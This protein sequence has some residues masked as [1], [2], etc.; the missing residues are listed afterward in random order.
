MDLVTLLNPSLSLD[1]G[2]MN[3]K[4]ASPQVIGPIL[5]QDE[6]MIGVVGLNGKTFLPLVAGSIGLTLG[7]I[8]TSG[9]STDIRFDV[10]SRGELSPSIP[11]FTINYLSRD[12]STS[13]ADH[14]IVYFTTT[15]G[16]AAQGSC[17]R[18]STRENCVGLAGVRSSSR[19]GI[20]VA[21][22]PPCTNC[23]GTN[24]ATSSNRYLVP[25]SP[26]PIQLIPVN[27]EGSWFPQTYPLPPSVDPGKF[28]TALSNVAY[29]MNAVIG[30]EVYNNVSI[31][32][33]FPD[34]N[35]NG[36][37]LENTS[38]QQI[39]IIP[40]K[41]FTSSRGTEQ[42][43]GVSCPDCADNTD[44]GLG[45]FCSI[46][47]RAQFKDGD[48][49]IDGITEYCCDP[50]DCGGG[51]ANS[52]VSCQYGFTQK[53]E[54]EDG[55][56]YRYCK[57]GE[58]RCNGD[59]KRPCSP[60]G[61]FEIV[62]QVCTLNDGSYSCQNPSQSSTDTNNLGAVE[63]QSEVIS[64]TEIAIIALSSAVLL[65]IVIYVVYIWAQKYQS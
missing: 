42:T 57:A 65:G 55:C 8:F 49:G 5:D 58:P 33:F 51:A 36:A 7:T 45:A 44:G 63:P 12:Q 1:T 34:I 41:Y 37:F 47:C 20:G 3:C 18:N 62:N 32:A 24:S 48:G 50:R 28:V 17:R 23:S 56:F 19:P 26:V 61:T 40:I 13:G 22:I 21:P 54:C 39:Y 29:T 46:A 52:C 2:N 9:E 6:V 16:A 38:A 11:T 43:A 31:S 30:G 60:T 25:G 14:P 10:D 27:G 59:C 35:Q 15:N 53:E 4:P 64:S